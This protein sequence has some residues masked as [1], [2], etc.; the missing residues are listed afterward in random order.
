MINKRHNQN[1][2][3]TR[4]TGLVTAHRLATWAALTILGI[5]FCRDTVRADGSSTNLSSDTPTNFIPSTNT[6]DYVKREE[7]IPMRDGVKLKTFIL[8]PKGITSAPI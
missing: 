7:M 6:F 5:M 3:G 4:K 1:E 8:V 2:I